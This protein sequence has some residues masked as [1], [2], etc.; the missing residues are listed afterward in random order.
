MNTHDFLKEFRHSLNRFLSNLTLLH[1]CPVLL[2]RIM[3]RENC[4]SKEKQKKKA[5]LRYKATEKPKKPVENTPYR[6]ERH[7]KSFNFE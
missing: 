4:L 2:L 3:A 7:C 6:R 1:P 5:V